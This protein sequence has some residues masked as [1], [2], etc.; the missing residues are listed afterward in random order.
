MWA[1]FVRGIVRTR[2]CAAS[3]PL[4]VCAG[5]WLLPTAGASVATCWCCGIAA[6]AYKASSTLCVD[7][8]FKPGSPTHM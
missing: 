8:C 1:S 2:L 4:L 5:A 7:T 3:M 6:A